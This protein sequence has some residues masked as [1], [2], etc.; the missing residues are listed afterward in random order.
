VKD[1]LGYFTAILENKLKRKKSQRKKSV[2]GR[3]VDKI[4]IF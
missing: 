1:G 4:G 3:G 2:G